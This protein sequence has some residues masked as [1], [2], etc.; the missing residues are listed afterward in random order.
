MTTP[1]QLKWL[2]KLLGF[3]YEIAYKKGSD[4]VAADAL[5]MVNQSGELLQMVVSSVASDV[6][7]KIKAEW[8]SDVT[9]Q[10]LIRSVKDKL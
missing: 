2:P 8:E 4:N 6:M 3:D 5:S 10:Q 9:M 7:D 1:F